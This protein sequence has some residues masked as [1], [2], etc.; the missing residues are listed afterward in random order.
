MDV[1][2]D[3]AS[4]ALIAAAQNLVVDHVTAAVVGAFNAAAIRA[5]LLKGPAIARR[6]YAD[7]QPRPYLDTDLLVAPSDVA[8]AESV[9]ADLEFVPAFDRNAD[10]GAHAASHAQ[11]WVRATDGA[12]VDLHHSL[13]G[14]AASPEQVWSALSSGTDRMRVA[15]AEVEV[16]GSAAGALHLALHAAQ[17][18]VR[19]PKPLEDLR[20]ATE[21]L[22]ESVWRGA[23]ALAGRLEATPSFA[24]GLRLVPGGT[25]IA[26]RLQL[27]VSRPVDL[28]LTARTPPRGA[29]TLERLAAAG[30]RDKLRLIRAKLAPA[31]DF[32]RYW[33]PLARRGQLGLALAYLGRPLWVVMRVPHALVAWT[34]ARREVRRETRKGDDRT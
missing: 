12:H 4:P 6:F 9:L 20:R 15:T 2:R 26:D 19:E 11:T 25:N 16:L 8:A 30:F 18:G 23:A 34:S 3:T 13:V 22:A 29:P 31:P 5:I 10:A 17:H 1:S 21:Q 7:G 24:I 33:S 27:P 14:L 28:V 32:L